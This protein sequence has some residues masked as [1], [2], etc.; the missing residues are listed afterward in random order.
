MRHGDERFGQAAGFAQILGGLALTIMLSS[1]GRADVVEYPDFFEPWEAA[2]PQFVTL[3]FTGLDIPGVLSVTNQYAQFGVYFPD[4]NEVVVESGS[5]VNDGWGVRGYV[6]PPGEIHLVFDVPRN[7]IAIHFPGCI[8][9]DLY[10]DGQL[11][12][13]E[14]GE[15]AQEQ[16]GF[17]GIISDDPFDEVWLSEAPGSPFVDDI[18]VGVPY[19]PRRPDRRC[20]GRTRGPR[21]T[22][23]ELGAVPAPSPGWRSLSC[24]CVSQFLGRGG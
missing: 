23:G 11:V 17:V 18:Y 2:A 24:R 22:P 16:Q 20:V 15:C 4:W 6:F 8:F 7:A 19:I 13:T 21:R 9:M 1:L 14:S 5:F 3:D 12:H 10:L